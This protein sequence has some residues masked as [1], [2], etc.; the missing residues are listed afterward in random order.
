MPIL[1]DEVSLEVSDTAA[2]GVGE[3]LPQQLPAAA[4]EQELLQTLALI[5]QRQERLRV[6]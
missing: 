1:I 6:D 5:Q 4:A 2:P 3:P